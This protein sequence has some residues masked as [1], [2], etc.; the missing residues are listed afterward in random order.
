[1]MNQFPDPS[2]AARTLAQDDYEFSVQRARP[3]LAAFAAA[4]DI[5][6]EGRQAVWRLMMQA[7]WCRLLGVPIELPDLSLGAVEA[8]TRETWR[9]CRS[10]MKQLPRLG[11]E[12]DRAST[13]EEMNESCCSVLERRMEL[14]AMMIALDDA[15]EMLDQGASA[16]EIKSLHR[17]VNRLDGLLA[18]LD[19]MLHGV[20]ELLG[21]VVDLPLLDNW[22]DMLAEEFSDTMPWWL[23]GELE[24]GTERRYEAALATM[25][26]GAVWERRV[27]ESSRLMRIADYLPAPRVELAAAAEEEDDNELLLAW[28]SPDEQW[29]ARLRIPEAPRKGEQTEIKL[30]IMDDA[31]RP[32]TCFA[33]ETTRV[34]DFELTLDA[35]ASATFPLAALRAAGGERRLLVGGQEWVWSG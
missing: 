1:M 20:E 30:F 32:A 31:D 12:F 14:W 18:E 4:Q 2:V 8:A 28:R 19:L 17:Q 35:Q 13:Q 15:L 26:S 3:H 5:S 33:G 25:P 6:R 24:Q 9:Y 7:G 10:L 27:A 11:A 21:I 16:G 34:G 22:R 23:S 29:I